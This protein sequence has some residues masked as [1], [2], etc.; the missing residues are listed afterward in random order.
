MR[1]IVSTVILAAAKSL[2]SLVLRGRS[3]SCEKGLA[4]HGKSKGFHACAST[5]P[6]EPGQ[7]TEFP[8][9]APA[10]LSARGLHMRSRCW[11]FVSV[12]IGP[13]GGSAYKCNATA[14]MLQTNTCYICTSQDEN[15]IHLLSGLF[16]VSVLGPNTDFQSSLYPSRPSTSSST[17]LNFS[18]VP[19][20]PQFRPL[21]DPRRQ[22]KGQRPDFDSPWS[23]PSSSVEANRSLRPFVW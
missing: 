1:C 11:V 5:V 10:K 17:S 18:S 6:L 12:M 19:S 23:P 7:R 14:R 4:P 15:I 3:P 16:L 2:R 13:K 8:I 9:S 22:R 21:S 20:Q